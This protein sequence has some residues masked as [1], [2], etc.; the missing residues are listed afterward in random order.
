MESDLYDPPGI[1]ELQDPVLRGGGRQ[2]EQVRFR[3]V[4]YLRPDRAEE[5]LAASA[6]EMAE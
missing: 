6:L 3:L 5:V 4:E 1:A 2:V